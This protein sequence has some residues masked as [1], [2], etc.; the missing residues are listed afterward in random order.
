MITDKQFNDAFTAAG[1]WFFLTQFELINN[2]KGSKAELID[3][4]YQSGFDAKRSGS[5]TRVSSSL[6]MIESNRA[7]E[8][9][10]KIKGSKLINHSHSEAE[11]LASDLL[12]KYFSI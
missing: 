2:W 8:A 1:G 12:A 9:L 5:Y 10:L 11:S 3:R 6:R 7:K 4:I